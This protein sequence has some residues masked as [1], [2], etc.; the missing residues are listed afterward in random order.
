[1]RS[2]AVSGWPNLQVNGYAD[3]QGTT[4]I[5]LLRLT[6]LSDNLLLAIFDGTLKWLLFTSPPE[7]LHCGIEQPSPGQYSTTLRQLSGSTP[8]QQY[9]NPNDV[10]AINF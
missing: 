6:P 2:L 9:T 3:T 7:Q 1:M 4:E 10:A 8:G 5:P